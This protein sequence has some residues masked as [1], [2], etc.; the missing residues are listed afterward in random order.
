MRAGRFTATIVW[1]CSSSAVAIIATAESGKDIGCGAAFDISTK[2][3]VPADLVGGRR[4][5]PEDLNILTRRYWSLFRVD[6]EMVAPL[7]INFPHISVPFSHD[8]IL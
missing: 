6:D 8:M 1:V 3:V 2:I 4:L 7:S 5:G